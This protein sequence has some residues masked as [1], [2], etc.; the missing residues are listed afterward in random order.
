[1]CFKFQDSTRDYSLGTGT[2]KRLRKREVW[3][4]DQEV[5][6]NYSLLSIARVYRLIE[7]SLD[8]S[9]LVR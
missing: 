3:G 4:R 5:E 6:Y 9:P 1:M 8:P 7:S 2:A